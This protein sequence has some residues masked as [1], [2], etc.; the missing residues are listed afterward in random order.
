MKMRSKK[1]SFALTA[2]IC[3]AVILSLPGRIVYSQGTATPIA[4]GQVFQAS[5]SA[6]SEVDTYTFDAQ[7]GDV[8]RVEMTTD[9]TFDPY[10]RL[11]G[12]DGSFIAEAAASGPG[13]ATIS[14]RLETAGTYR[15]LAMDYGGEETGAYALVL[16]GG[17]AATHYSISFGQTI[18]GSITTPAHQDVYTFEVQAG[19]MVLVRMG[20]EEREGYIRNS[21]P[22]GWLIA[23]GNLSSWPY[24]FPFR[25]RATGTWEVRVG[26]TVGGTGAY[27]LFVQR[28]NGPEAATPIAFGQ[29]VQGAISSAY[30]AD[31]YT[32][33]GFKGDGVR[34][35]ITT[36]TGLEPEISLYG[37]DGS[38]VTGGQASSNGPGYLY[39][40]LPATGT[41]T[42]VARDRAGFESGDYGNETG[43]YQ[44]FLQRVNEPA[45]ATP[46]VFGQV[47]P[48]S[49]S[50]AYEVDTYT[51]DAQAGDVVRVQMTTATTLDPN[52]ELFGPDGSFLASNNAGGP[53]TTI[54]SQRLA[55]SGTY[56]VLAFDP[57]G[58]ETG[59]YTIVLSGG[60]AV[61]PFSISFGETK[62]GSMTTP[63][64]QDLY[65]FTAEAWDVVFV[66][67]ITDGKP[68]YIR[69]AGPDG[70]VIA[71]SDVGVL[72]YEPVFQAGFTG[73]YEV[74]V[75]FSTGETGNYWIFVQRLNKAGM[76]KPLAFAQTSQ[77]NISSTYEVHTYTFDAVKG[78][79]VRVRTSTD[80]E[81]DPLVRIYGPDGSRIAENGATGPGVAETRAYIPATGT[82]M[83]MVR[84]GWSNY[85]CCDLPNETGQYWIFAQWVNRP[86]LATQMTFGQTV[87]AALDEAYEVDTCT[88]EAHEGDVARVEIS[89]ETTLYPYIELYGPDGS[90]IGGNGTVGPGT[91]TISQRLGADGAYTLL[92]FDTSNRKETGAYRIVLSGGPAV[93]PIALSFG[94]TV[95]GSITTPARQ[96]IY[97]FHAEE[98]DA[99]LLRIRMEGEAGYF[100]LSA[101]NGSPMDE[102]SVGTWPY[103]TWFRASLTGTYEVRIGFSD[104]ATGNYWVALQRPNNPAVPIKIDFG[105]TLSSSISSA[106]QQNTYTFDGL[107]G[108]TVRLRIVTGTALD[109]EIALYGP[110]GSAV[111][112]SYALGPGTRDLDV[113]LPATGTYTLIVRDRAG[114]QADDYGNETGDYRI[115]VQR[116]D[117]PV[118]AT[119]LTFGQILRASLFPAYDVDTYTFDAHEG[120]VVRVEMS[121]DT[122]LD[123][124]IQLYAPNGGFIAD[125]WAIG[126][127]TATISRRLETDGT[128]TLLASD[129]SGKETGEYTIYLSGGP[130]GAPVAMSFGQTIA[131]SITTPNHQDV[132]TFQ[133][134]EWDVV[135][136][137]MSPDGKEG[138]LR[139]SGPDGSL[140]DERSVSSF[141]YEIPFQARSAGT[142]EARV[143]FT[144]G[145]TG[146]YWIFVQ[147][148]NNPGTAAHIALAETLQ[149]QIASPYE[150]D[151]YT[152]DAL[153]DDAVRLTMT[154]DGSLDPEI[155]LYGPDGSF[156][157][158][159]Y[160]SG[161]GVLDLEARLP[162]TGTYTML[163]N[164]RAGIQSGDYG[165]E[166]GAYWLFVQRLNRPAMATKIDFG[167]ALPFSL[168]SAYEEDTYTFDALKGDRLRLRV[169]T[170]T[171]LDPQVRIYAPDGTPLA[172]GI[173]HGPG[174]RDIDV[175]LPVTGTYTLVA[176]DVSIQSGDGSNETGE[177]RIFMQRLNRPASAAEIKFGQ[178]LQ[179]SLATAYEV[180]TYTFNALAGDMVRVE[181]ITTTTLDPYIQL[182]GSDG[183][184][185]AQ[186]GSSGPGA[187]TILRRLD[188]D[189]A[190]TVLAFNPSGTETGDYTI[191]LSGGPET[192]V[193]LLFGQTVVGSISTPA[194][195]NLYTFE[196]EPGDVVL[197][198][199]SPGEK[200]GYVRIAGP[201]GALIADMDSFPYEISVAALYAG[202]Y[203][204]R[205]GLTGG[206]T[207]DYRLFVQRLNNPLGATQ[208]AFGETRSAAL[209]SA[210]EVDTYTLAA[211]SGDRVWVTMA[212]DTGLDPE[213][214][215]YAPDGSSLTGGYAYGPG[216][217]E[218]EVQLLASGTYTLLVRDRAG[219]ESGDYGAETGNYRLFVQ[220]LNN[221]AMATR[222]E[223]GK[224][225]QGSLASAYEVDTYTF[226]ARKGTLVRVEMSTDTTLDP[227]IQLYAPD[228]SLIAEKGASGP[229][230]AAVSHRIEIDGVYTVVAFNPSG[231]ETGEYTLLLAGGSAEAPVP[232]SFGQ[233]FAGSISIPAEQALCTFQAELGDVVLVRVSTGGK[234]GY[235]QISGPDG[236]SVAESPVRDWPYEVSFEAGSTGTCEVR[237]GLSAGGTG[238]YWIFV[239]RLDNPAMATGLAFGET[240]SASVASSYEVD[241]YTVNALK[242][243]TVRVTMTT[244]SGLEP[245]FAVYAPDGS[246]VTYGSGFGPGWVDRDVQLAATG[247]YTV[248]ARDQAGTR[249]GDYGNGTGNYWIFV[250]RL[251]NPAMAARMDFG[252]PRVGAIGT[253]CEVDTYT[254]DA[255][256]G[257]AIWARTSSE[258]GL[259]PEF[260]VYG[261]DGAF[262]T[263]GSAFGPGAG[264]AW[265]RLNAAG[266]YTVLVRDRATGIDNDY[267]NETGEYRLFLQRLNRPAKATRIDFGQTVRAYLTLPYEVDTYTLDAFAGDVVRVQMNADAGPYPRIELYNPEGTFITEGDIFASGTATVSAKLTADGA[268]TVLASNYGGGEQTGEYAVALILDSGVSRWKSL[269]ITPPE[270]FDAFGV[271][272]G[273]FAPLSKTYVLENKD[274][275]PIAWTLAK[276]QDWLLI[277]P[278]SGTIEAG[279]TQSVTVSIDADRAK[280]L[281]TGTYVDTLTFT[282]VTEANRNIFRTASLLVAPVDEAVLQVTPDSAFS[283]SGPL[284]G[285]FEPAGTVYSLKN[286][287]LKPLNWRVSKTAYWLSLSSDHGSL[288]PGATAEVTVSITGVARD[289]VL[290]LYKDAVA[291]TNADNGYGTTSRDVSLSIGVSPSRLTGDLSKTTMLLGDLATPLQISGQITPK[292]CE[293]GAFVDVVLIS[294]T[295][296][297][298]HRSVNANVL[299]QFSYAV[300]CDEI[301]R[302]GTW[303][304][305]TTW[306]GD[307]CLGSAVSEQQL[308]RVAK[309]ESRLTVDAGSRAVKLGDLVD[310]SGKFTPD[311]DCGR[312]LTAREMKLVIIG[313][314]GRSDFQTVRTADRFGHFVLQ[315]YKGF[316]ALGQWSL[317][318][319]FVGD[320]A[321]RESASEVI[322]V[323]VVETAGYAVIVQGKIENEE[324]LA[325]HQ[326]TARFV[327]NQLRQ[328]GLQDEDIYFLSY[329]AGQGVDGM[330]S[331]AAVQYAITQW[332]RDRMNA[333]PANLYVV[334]VDHGLTNKFLVYPDEITAAD[335]G[336]WLNALQASLRGQAAVQELVLLLGFCRSGSFVDEVS[337]WK[338]VVIASAAADESSYK[339]PLDPNDPTGVRDG[340]FFMSEFF[341]GA[342]VGK[343]VLSSFQEA[344][345][346]TRVFTSTGTGAPNGPYADDSRQHPLLDDNGDG[347]GEN[348]PSGDPGQDGSL[349]RSLFIGV[350]SVTGN[351]PGDV[352]VTEV[353][354]TQVLEADASS[355]SFWARVDNNKRMRSLWLEVKPPGYDPGAGGTDQIAMD[356]PRHIY[357]GYSDQANRYEWSEVLGF[358]KPGTY[359]V[360]FFARDNETGNQSS[361]KQAIVYKS[362][363]GNN[364]PVPFHLLSPADNTEH[365]TVLMVSWSESTDPEGHPLTYTVEISEDGS[366]S[367]VVHRAER[368]AQN[369]YFVG[370]EAGLKDLNTYYWRVTA[371]DYYGAQTLS[372]EAWSFR[373]NNTNPLAG[374]IAGRVY[375]AYTNQ[376]IASAVV[377]AEKQPLT[378]L[379]SGNF[380][381]QVEAGTYAITADAAGFASKTYP[382][383]VVR[384]A[385]VVTK[386][387]ALTPT[388]EVLI[389]DLNGDGRVDLTD[390]ILALRV[391]TGASTSGVIRSD[392]PS[393][394]ADVDGDG[395]VGLAEVLYVLQYMAGLI[396]K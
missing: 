109:P 236:V 31:T 274:S 239:Q 201:D 177:Y 227:Y 392:Y 229:G 119:Q 381:G 181:M 125:A 81:L 258:T 128:Y 289:L 146:S 124:Y 275:I 301:D 286:A 216:M 315:D 178:I 60:Q 327:Y 308:L 75:G 270:G 32:F 205:V 388:G 156:I 37:P 362:I 107:Q 320:E 299:G 102:R 127:G 331:K 354:G 303:T 187:A 369:Y 261:P 292:P 136:V 13:T 256:A 27:W 163:A 52:I 265:A 326:K 233:T 234:E 311:P 380:I 192:P 310:I 332:A 49:L 44:I 172:E 351:A 185:V 218:R 358:T 134:E 263:G 372:S 232:L 307:R 224:I 386:D 149:A 151:T 158:W 79:W 382:G 56:T 343:S 304:I 105:Q 152:F 196:A 34:L 67:M 206:N 142:Y 55:T 115:Y 379:P 170:D 228:G 69:V 97:T 230:T 336:A 153:R 36:D 108:D 165:N 96:D 295:G 1:S 389:G 130:V 147:R 291:F 70:S 214:L 290:G 89:T 316:N 302:D 221:P 111:T 10:I 347:L 19:D 373:T 223:P 169:V 144:L 237:V 338:R 35:R 93:G 83:L 3:L 225:L 211:V 394:G 345:Q 190:Y 176:R 365:R 276:T 63:A 141:P 123:P 62:A 175:E 385:E 287:G 104:E 22:D 26:F 330:P 251:N 281:A 374:W 135:L 375:D 361:L 339:G 112:W 68:G 71:E 328:R 350:S 122:T 370:R 161:P 346:K 50:G 58:K 235:V 349:S 314:E 47:L 183:S 272:G 72:P 293:G 194:Q 85:W 226:E 390:A 200:Q 212:T 387:F 118:G 254:F 317:Q 259:D 322:T 87:Q 395:R 20:T 300:T 28:L 195:E 250:Q 366:F 91:A 273:T 30:E 41:Y 357:S 92:V 242:G 384:D 337:G 213:I 203:K 297:E 383:V 101:P 77:A 334:L 78:D 266:T 133:A 313:P 377:T 184:L 353:S 42:L 325:S 376:A 45:T 257:D 342:A 94:Q 219:T 6:A 18:S 283:S 25:A 76:V 341:K 202:T 243:D 80:T 298:I 285:P 103:E 393:S 84:D 131:G 188:T 255:F 162:A 231:R 33:D 174:A 199:M 391:L 126:P 154:T 356:L 8:V 43:S 271:S 280:T 2:I 305:R 335:L 363:A 306:N 352:Q 207:G 321:Y 160:A 15:V 333:K 245:E 252:E 309:A 120:D 241:T 129:P 90:F 116:L 95:A 186:N 98:G 247:T 348:T 73:T 132:Y 46:I 53:G 100:R 318:A 54:I 222:M 191:L 9:T 166:T 114:L 59:D 215:L 197:V 296:Q 113:Q 179:G 143:G 82:Y 155:R 106:Y 284:Q 148:L 21:N 249:T 193:P 173:A 145:G 137:R 86:S 14:C 244:D 64:H 171:G 324:G 180:D 368:L 267:G 117:S 38:F 65:T 312:D 138:Y 217:V 268:Y 329:E 396:G 355:V 11:F 344:V 110:D 182:F 139:I 367:K 198:R 17:S 4:F 74:R 40:R 51:F 12:P 29:T 168:S 248:L 159:G 99:V 360:F 61:T 319:L 189:G 269:T 364:P 378:V 288:E 57:S 246:L 277:S 167:Q 7:A 264:D 323:Q 150:V 5:L 253:A 24:D 238:S 88:F 39:A 359:Q 164:D 16:S 278:E 157:N 294:P 340:E 282:N 240:L 140:I 208:I 371:T 210:Y 260:A 279:G 262:V 66:S 48:A 204:V 121:T 23:E 220:R 209:D